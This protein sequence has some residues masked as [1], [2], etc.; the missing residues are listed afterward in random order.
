[1]P[2]DFYR[3]H[4]QLFNYLGTHARACKKLDLMPVKDWGRMKGNSCLLLSTIHTL[5]SIIVH[6]VDH[7]ATCRQHARET[8]A[9]LSRIA[10]GEPL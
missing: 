10:D 9:G 7:S 4:A 1:M 6:G 2:G 8:C 3:A 5:V